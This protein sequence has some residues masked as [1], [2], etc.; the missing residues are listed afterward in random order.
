MLQGDGIV[1]ISFSRLY[2][3]FDEVIGCLFWVTGY[4]HQLGRRQYFEQIGVD[5][6]ANPSRGWKDSDF[7]HLLGMAIDNE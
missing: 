6:G 2:A 4:Q 5:T 7:G 3:G 1:E